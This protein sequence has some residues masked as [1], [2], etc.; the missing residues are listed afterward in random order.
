[1]AKVKVKVFLSFKFKEDADLRGSFFK[2]AHR[3]SYDLKDYS[4]K[5]A[6]RPQDGS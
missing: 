2:Q 3:S 1:M 4:L 6:Y 5:E